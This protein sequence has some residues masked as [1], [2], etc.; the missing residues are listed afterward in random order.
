MV[1]FDFDKEKEAIINPWDVVSVEAGVLGD[2]PEIAVSCFE[3]KTFERL[4]KLLDGKVIAEPRNANAVFPI[5]KA[6]YKE[7]EV[8]LFMMDMGAAGAGGVLE[9]VYA[10]GVE[11]IVVFGSC[12]VL[13]E[14]IEESSIIIPDKAI[15]DEG[16]SYHYAPPSDEIDVNLHFRKEFIE[17]LEEM[18]VSY[19]TGKVWTTDAFYRETKAKMEKRKAQGCICVDMECSALAAVSQF[20]EKKLFQFFWAA[21]NLDG[22]KWD[23]RGLSQEVNFFEKDIC[24]AL[25]LELAIR[26]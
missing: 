9:E 8:A 26:I 5:Y 1:L 7:K 22:E 12:G 20:R 14:G 15:R 23:P 10:L 18:N 17:L 21:D 19:R 3:C 25:A 6:K 16:L 11:K 24:S 13:D 4:V 2:M